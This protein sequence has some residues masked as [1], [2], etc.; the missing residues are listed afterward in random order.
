MPPKALKASKVSTKDVIK[1]LKKL[2]KKQ[3]QTAITYVL[4]IYLSC[5]VKQL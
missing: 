3:Q 1:P 4:S 5:I 2:S